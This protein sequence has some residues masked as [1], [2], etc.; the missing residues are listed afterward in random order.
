[1]R[2]AG[3]PN[4]PDGTPMRYR[5]AVKVGVIFAEDTGGEIEPPAGFTASRRASVVRL[6]QPD[7]VAARS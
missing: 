2:T 3:F 4:K 6:T 1:M 7:Q 5:T